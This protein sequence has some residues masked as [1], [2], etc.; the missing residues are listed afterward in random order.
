MRDKLRGF[1][2]D[3]VLAAMP[4]RWVGPTAPWCPGCGAQGSANCLVCRGETDPGARQ[5]NLEA[6]NQRRQF[7]DR[8]VTALVGHLEYASPRVK[9]M[10]RESLCRLLAED[11]R[12]ASGGKWRGDFAFG[13]VVGSM[14]LDS[15]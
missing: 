4:K 1:W 13:A 6:F 7:A 15:D 12:A 2:K 5:A 9:A 8:E 10:A 3:R 14:F 11:F